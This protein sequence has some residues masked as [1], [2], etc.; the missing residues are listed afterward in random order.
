MAFSAPPMQGQGS[1][2]PYFYPQSGMVNGDGHSY[3]GQGAQH[4]A[5][6]PPGPGQFQQPPQMKDGPGGPGMQ[7]PMLNQP[8][9]QQPGHPQQ[10]MMQPQ[11][12]P[13]MSRP[14]GVIPQMLNQPMSNL[15]IN[16]G[17]HKP[18]QPMV[19]GMPGVHPQQP[20]ML[21][22]QGP[23]PGNMRSDQQ[24]PLRQ[25]APRMAT[26][27]APPTTG[28]NVGLSGPPHPGQPRGMPPHSTNLLPPTQRFPMTTPGV[29]TGPG[30]GAH[31]SYHQ[32]P[33]QA[34]INLSGP[35]MGNTNT[36][37]T[38]PMTG[39]GPAPG[40][41]R[42]SP[43]GG[44]GMT[45]PMTQQARR[46]DPD[47]IPSPIQVMKDDQDNFKDTA[48]TT[49]VRGR[50]PPLI[51]TKCVIRDDGNCSP[52]YMRSTLYNIPNNQDVLKASGVPFAVS[53]TPL[54][55]S[56]REENPLQ[57]VDHGANGPVRCNRCK[58]YMNPFMQFIDGGRRF[59]CN[60]CSYSSE[61]PQEYFSH[62]DHQ[63]LRVDIYQRPELC[64]GSYE[65]VATAD[66]CKNQKPPEPPAYI[67]MIEASYQ[68]IQ[69][70]MLRILMREIPALLE[71]LP[72]MPGQNSSSVKVGF[73]TY[74]S[75]LHFYNVKSNLAQPQ[76][77]IVSDV[78]DVFVP[79]LDGFLVD[80]KESKIV[81]ESLIEQI[82]I[83]FAETRETEIVLAPVVQAGL[84]ALKSAGISGKLLIFHT[85]L[86]ISEAPGKL[87]NRE[88]RKVLATEKE[89]TILCPQTN[90]YEKLAK[91][92]VESGVA[93]DLFLFPNAY[94]DVATV[95]AL[96]SFTGGQLY[97]Y[98]FFKESTHGEQFKQDLIQNIERNV[99]L[100]TI[101]RLRT[102][103]GLRPCEFYGNFNMNN[104]TDVELALVNSQTSVVI[105]I[106]HDDKLPE[107]S[108]AYLQCA[109]LYTSVN[110]QRRLRI[111]NL[112][113]STCSQLTDLFRCCE[114]DTFTNYVAKHAIK[115]ATTS[116]PKTIR[117]NI[118]SQAASILA[119]YR[120]HCA[121][122]SSAGQLILPECMK[123]LPLYSNSVLKSDALIGGSEMSS[124]D[125]SWLMQTVL[126]M[127]I[128]STVS[129]FYPRLIPVH[130]VN[131]NETTLPPQI[132]CSEDRIK[133]NGVYLLENSIVLFLWIGLHVNP[134]WLQQVF[135][136]S[137]IGHVD[138]EMTAL[139]ELDTALSR[140]IRGI[141]AQIQEERHRYMKV[142]IVRQRDKLE[143]WFKHY[144]VE[145]KGLT[146]ASQSYVDFLCLM[147]KEVRNLLN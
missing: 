109:L 110:G 119:C 86:P 8:R 69:S 123:L 137:T 111:H 18:P 43:T 121:A 46:I 117:E 7:P 11:R 74:N 112:A 140:R 55:E 147:H 89:K 132:R 32:Q 12:P 102:S 83:M 4:Q 52:Q 136:V 76:M 50:V 131:L 80:A 20:T 71:K 116:V 24:S 75:T 56:L 78:N 42:P 134:D 33:G 59:L 130:D 85:S 2:P 1:R 30:T 53:I 96:T 141:I 27:I 104:T 81:I 40:Q 65:Y 51:T 106:R 13:N 17:L 87:K 114:M 34:P 97:R 101:M 108:V 73:V 144:L 36:Q 6:G 79:L 90:F 44:V 39:Y 95:G 135:G 19:P 62:L 57:L 88:D 48:F 15:Q 118:I 54:A 91:S 133:E 47:Q 142:S 5:G 49:S 45:S 70:G 99:G 125:R 67:F 94:I 3:Q 103:T 145:D 16:D 115:E 22:P 66:Y 93:V 25:F 63:G 64:L 82:S 61:V 139:P 122:P 129:Y 107:D 68:S 126:G 143:P 100:D 84:D 113:L 29:T 98:N 77:M 60:I 127:D 146:A 31:P 58:A 38:Q 105:E 9:H 41:V 21:P 120:Q 10:P 72:K 26:G 35:M 14:P 28:P 138:I 92:C 23:M 124:D 128:A 37:P